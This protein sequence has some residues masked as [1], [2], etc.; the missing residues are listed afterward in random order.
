MSRVTGGCRA[1]D[2]PIDVTDNVSDEFR[3]CVIGEIRDRFGDRADRIYAD[4]K[5]I[6]IYRKKGQRKRREPR[7][8]AL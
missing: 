3:C 4:R 7:V 2:S 6:I 5:I 8:E 1:E